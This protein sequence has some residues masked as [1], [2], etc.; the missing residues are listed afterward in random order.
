MDTDKI[1]LQQF[2]SRHPTQAAQA[3][4]SLTD[5]DIVTF[6]E[7]MPLALNAMLVSK[8]KTYRGASCLQLVRPELA[9]ELTEQ[10]D[11]ATAEA[12]LRHCEIPFRNKLLNSILPKRAEVL[13]QKLGYKAGTVGAWMMPTVF[14]LNKETRVKDALEMIKLEKERVSSTIYIVDEED[15]L[16][17]NIKLAELFFAD[18]T[19]LL[20]TIMNTE[21]PKVFAD[22]QIK[23]MQNHTVWYEHLAIPVVNRSGKLIGILDAESCQ[24]SHTKSSREMTEE[25]L[26]TSNAL[27]EVYRIG[28]MGFIQ[29]LS[30]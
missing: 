3:V 20:A 12:L 30:K 6:M 28:L 27:G 24:K 21:I 22:L 15:K 8:M 23:S 25:V 13:N 10:V 17:G 11:M 5:D 16:V 29:S 14:A 19:T 4:E 26:E 18:Q 9:K 2:I 1:L 7:E